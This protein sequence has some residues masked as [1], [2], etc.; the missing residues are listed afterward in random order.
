MLFTQKAVGV[1]SRVPASGGPAK[2]VT[3]LEK[4]DLMHRWPQFLPD[5]N[6]FLFYVKTQNPETSGTYLASL[7]K[8]GRKL[9]LR[10]GATGVF[11]P[12]APLLYCR[13]SAL[14]AQPFEA[15]SGELQGQPETVTRP[16]LRG[17][18]G[19]YRDL[20]AVSGSGILLFR[21]GSA[22]KRLTWMD[23]RGN[24][25]GRIG[26]PGEILSVSLSPDDRTAGLSFFSLETGVRAISMVDLERDT[27]T[28]FAEPA[29]LPVWA[30]DGGT[31]FYR[32][33][34]ERFEIRRK[35][36]RSGPGEDA[37]GVVDTFATPHSVSPDGRYLL[38]TRMGR[39]FDIGVKDLQG[40]G[41]PQGRLATEFA[42]QTPR[43]SPHGH[44]C[45]DSS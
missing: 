13:T 31:I 12:P 41:D 1:I 9:V 7:D 6:R 34:G 21:A 43:F 5:G 44:W 15:G 23:R 24:P 3:T 11:L 22:Q 36:V 25:I 45:A 27:V 28:P 35:T 17:D 37:I 20:F 39:S 4:G 32:Q 18:L 38:Y 8:A 30:P 42:G 33:E 16:V 19:S 26:S 29:S 40:N 2:P 10:N 14:L